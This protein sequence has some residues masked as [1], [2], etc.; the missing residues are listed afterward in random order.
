MTRRGISLVEMV[1]AMAICAV[2]S[3]I[4][5]TTMASLFQLD[6]ATSLH[7]IERTALRQL[8]TTLRQDLHRAIDCRWNADSQRL[9]LLQPQQQQV[10]YTLKKG[11]WVRI[12]S[13]QD[14]SPVTT[15]YRLNVACLWSCQP[16][17][18]KQG[19]LVHIDFGTPATNESSGSR[20]TLRCDVV[21]VVGRDHQLFH[22]PP[23]N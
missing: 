22:N 12:A 13:Q 18:A 19:T 14:Q 10:E 8:S 5:V 20:P 3:G 1:A 2:L 21:A 17:E 23:K 7:R 6:R 11:R 16:T 4:A 15:A 9:V